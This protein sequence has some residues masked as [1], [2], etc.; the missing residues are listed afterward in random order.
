MI[1]KINDLDPYN[2]VQFHD[3]YQLER[4]DSSK[5]NEQEQGS[6]D[7]EISE[8]DK[9]SRHEIKKQI[10]NELGYEHAQR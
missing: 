5:K 7:A 8:K 2:E 9:S 1:D 6:Q 4:Q 10:D 3:P